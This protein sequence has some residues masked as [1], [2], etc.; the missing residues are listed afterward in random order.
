MPTP[1]RESS[2]AIQEADATSQA[3]TMAQSSVPTT[4]S[5][6]LAGDE[7]DMFSIHSSDDS[8]DDIV[9]VQTYAT[10]S[11][12]SASVADEDEFDFVD[13]SEHENEN[14]GL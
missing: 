3:G 7:D 4:P 11:T 8:D 12:R 2:P 14:E 1:N 5:L 6:S 13:E 10:P 9:Q